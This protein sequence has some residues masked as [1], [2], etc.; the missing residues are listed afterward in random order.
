VKWWR[1]AAEQGDA[2]AFSNF[3]T[4]YANGI[5]VEKDTVES[6]AWVNIADV[7]HPEVAAIRDK[8]EG[9]L[10]PAVI[11]AGQKNCANRL[12]PE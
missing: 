1:K 5:G 7:N 12:M 3:G 4:C 11:S 6:F 10:S 8:L 9:A 2:L